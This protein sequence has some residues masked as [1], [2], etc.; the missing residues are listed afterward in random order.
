MYFRTV[1]QNSMRMNKYSNG[2]GLHFCKKLAQQLGGDLT[3]NAQQK[4]GSEFILML[5]VKKVEPDIR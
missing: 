4:K 3:F 5:R 1:D 2:I